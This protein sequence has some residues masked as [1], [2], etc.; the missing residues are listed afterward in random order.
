MARLLAAAARS[1]RLPSL[2]LVNTHSPS[3]QRDSFPVEAGRPYDVTVLC[4][5]ADE[6]PRAIDALPTEARQGYGVGF[7]FWETEE[8]PAAYRDRP[9]TSSTIWTASEYVA[10]AVGKVVSKPVHVCPLPLAEPRPAS[11]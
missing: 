9:P 7:W 5:N 4:A 1:D 8:L 11:A 3:R 2:A 10:E 6:V